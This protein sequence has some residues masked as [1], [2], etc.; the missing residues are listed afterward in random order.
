LVLVEFGK[1]RGLCAD[2][3]LAGFSGYRLVG[4]QAAVAANVLHGVA[5][6]SEDAANEQAAMAVGGVFFAADQGHAEAFHAALK[7]RNG[8][9]K[10]G[11]V[12]E[13]AVKD[14][15]FGVVVGRIRWASTQ[16]RAEKEIANPRFLQGALHE[17][18]VKLRDVLRVGRAARID[19]YFNVMLAQKSKPDR[20]V[21][22]GVADGE[23]AAHA[24]ALAEEDST[25]AAIRL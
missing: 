6:L 8:C 15:A 19:Y 11:V 4:F 23:E 14:A 22:V 18:L 16:L 9:L 10:E 25:Y 12:A 7:P 1:E 2:Q 3:R 5:A 13:P 17:L 24:Q 21:V 20:E